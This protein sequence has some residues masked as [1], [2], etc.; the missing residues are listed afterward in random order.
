MREEPVTDLMAAD[1]TERSSL[2][3][4]V[5]Y[6]VPPNA[7]IAQ[8]EEVGEIVLRTWGNSFTLGK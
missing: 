2:T 4:T 1:P 8:G 3:L 7:P 6:S 5:P